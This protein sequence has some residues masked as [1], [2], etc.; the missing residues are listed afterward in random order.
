MQNAHNGNIS[1][2]KYYYEYKT[3]ALMGTDLR[4]TLQQSGAHTPERFCTSDLNSTSKDNVLPTL[5]HVL[6]L[7]LQS[8]F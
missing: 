2:K 4:L 3:V 5:E 1:L 6:V 7:L 8:T